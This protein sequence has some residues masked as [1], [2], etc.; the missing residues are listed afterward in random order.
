MKIFLEYKHYFT[1]GFILIFFIF[2]RVYNLPQS[3]LF[4]N[5]MGRDYM[6]LYDWQT[7]WKPP[8]LGPQTS[9]FSYNQSAWYFYLLFPVYVLTQS[10]YSSFITLLI[11]SLGCLAYVFYI[12]RKN[13]E[14]LWILLVVFWLLAIQPQS[15]I[16]NRFVWNP[17]FVPYFLTVA[18]GLLPILLQKF[19]R[20]TYFIFVLSLAFACGFSYSA[21]PLA[22]LLCLVVL[23]VQ[24]KHWLEMVGL[25]AVAGLIVLSPM[26]AFELRHDFAL[27]QLA[28]K[29][30]TLPQAAT[31]LN[32]KLLDMRNLFF[33]FPQSQYR[34]TIAAI[35]GVILVSAVAWKFFTSKVLTHKVYLGLFIT[36]L[37]ITL[38]LP[39]ALQS[40]YI[41]PL[42]V[43][44]FF[45][46]AT[47]TKRLGFTLVVVLTFLWLD[48]STV[49]QYFKPA[50]RSISEMEQC[51]AVYCA[52]AT[53]PMYV[54]MESGIL[55]G[56][57]NAPEHRYFMSQAG[58]NV[59][60]IE[61]EPNAAS[62]MAVINDSAQFVASQSA[63]HELSLFGEYTTGPVITCTDQLSIQEIYK[64]TGAENEVVITPRN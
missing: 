36:V 57:H 13:S 42:L 53:Q 21:V 34:S 11:I 44:S 45:A 3:L 54:S 18:L 43:L 24:R 25:S 20:V 16:Q 26:L 41:F 46:L 14:M 37:V 47:V 28:I 39:V 33:M 35:F 5:D 30:Q 8:L 51:Y 1:L 48:P 22:I 55:S 63:Y 4:F 7:T 56:Y 27:T 19:T 29:G 61:L 17:S 6:V 23:A 49:S 64:P 10:S 62:M 40:H 12:H 52:E 2:L 58:C 31:T 15:V 60:D 32:A 59:K 38:L 9:A 50:A